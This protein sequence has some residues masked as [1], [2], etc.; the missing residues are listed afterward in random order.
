MFLASTPVQTK[1]LLILYFVYLSL[2]PGQL[3]YCNHCCCC[4]PLCT[5]Q[6]FTCFVQTNGHVPF[7]LNTSI[8]FHQPDENTHFLCALSFWITPT[9]S[10]NLLLIT[11]NSLVVGIAFVLIFASS[12]LLAGQRTKARK[13]GH[14]DKG[15]WKWQVICFMPQFVIPVERKVCVRDNSKLC[16]NG[17]ET[18]AIFN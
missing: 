12:N 18:S 2:L 7:R 17:N 5:Y 11:V 6:Y 13:C 15:V 16:W 14:S 4:L 8:G 3:Y 10:F 1:N 9:H